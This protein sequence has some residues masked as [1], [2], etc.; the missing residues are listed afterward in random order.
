VKSENA[1]DRKLQTL[2]WNVLEKAKRHG[3]RSD[4]VKNFIQMREDDK[5]FVELAATLI[6]LFETKRQELNALMGEDGLVY[7]PDL[8]KEVTTT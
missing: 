3:S 4:Q 6:I 2:L 5:E 8:R 7:V 1:T